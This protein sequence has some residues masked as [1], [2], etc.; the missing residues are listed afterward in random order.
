MSSGYSFIPR[1]TE[2]LLNDILHSADH[3]ERLSTRIT[4]VNRET[5]EDLQIMV[6]R[7]LEIIGEAIRQLESSDEKNAEMIPSRAGM[8]GLRNVIAHQYGDIDYEVI[9]ITR[10]ITV[11]ELARQVRE[12][13][14]GKLD[15][16]ASG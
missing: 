3:L 13:L 9:A 14:D 8:V 10:H 4:V 16:P 7:R 5:D 11:P 15:A 12:L 1:R 6:E 2:K